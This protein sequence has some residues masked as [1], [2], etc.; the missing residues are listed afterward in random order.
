MKKYFVLFFAFAFLV[1]GL[2]IFFEVL[3][4]SA[5]SRERNIRSFA[6]PAGAQKI[7]DNVYYLGR[8]HD[9]S[10]GADVEGY[11]VIYRKNN[12][13]R[14]TAAQKAKVP[15]APVCYSFLAESTKWKAV[16]PWVMNVSNSRGLDG[17]SL[18]A[19]MNYG[20]GSW[21]DAADGFLGNAAS[22]DILGAGSTTSLP[23][24]ADETATDGINEVYFGDIAE[25]DVIG[26]TIVW[27]SFNAPK[28]LRQLVEWDMIFDEVDFGWS[29]FGEEGKMDFKNIAIH[30]LGHAVGMGDVYESACSDATMYGYAGFGETKKQTLELPDV[31]GVS[32]LY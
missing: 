19:A 25:S 24:Q 11:A 10:S 9:K 1:V 27:G 18:F 13:A 3:P 20:I 32:V 7:S 21:E 15:K 17:A 2:F 8:G 16:E 4:A 5:L 22:F 12:F 30:E 28:R 14:P 29:L 31:K 26:V 6:L 23:L